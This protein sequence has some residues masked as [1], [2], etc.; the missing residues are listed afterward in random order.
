VGSELSRA[1]SG[2]WTGDDSSTVYRTL[3]VLE[4]PGY[5]RHHHGVDGREEFHVLPTEDHG[6]FHCQVRGTSWWISAEEGAA[7][8]GADGPA[9]FVPGRLRRT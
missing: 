3:D 9:A 5:V 6:H 2:S 4:D 1:P 7:I 8:A